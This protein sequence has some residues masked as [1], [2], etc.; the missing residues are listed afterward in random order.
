MKKAN[1]ERLNQMG[2]TR[3]PSDEREITH[4]ISGCDPALKG[5]REYAA[6][7]VL[8]KG[9]SCISDFL[10]P[11]PQYFIVKSR[12][13]RFLVDTQGGSYIRYAQKI[14]E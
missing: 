14:V 6:E 10:L 3:K 1:Q 11:V 8:D 2:W 4:T 7:E 12:G 5:L 9:V 13:T